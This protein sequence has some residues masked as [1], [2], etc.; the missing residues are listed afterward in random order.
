[1]DT[2]VNI[3]CNLDASEDGSY[4]FN[5]AWTYT[6]VSQ[7]VDLVYEEIVVTRPDGL[8]LGGAKG[9]AHLVRPG[10]TYIGTGTGAGRLNPGDNRWKL[11]VLTD[12]GELL[13]MGDGNFFA[14]IPMRDT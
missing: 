5:W 2:A 9:E 11:K 12:D 14:M 7:D 3:E 4:T 6:G 10:Q 8:I 13:G 1:M